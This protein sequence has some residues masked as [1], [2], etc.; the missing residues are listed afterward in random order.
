MTLEVLDELVDVEEEEEVS[1]ADTAMNTR[2]LIRA[3]A[4]GS[5]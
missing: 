2:R 3:I 5:A 1:S 4:Q